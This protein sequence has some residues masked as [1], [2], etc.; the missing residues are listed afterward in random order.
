[1]LALGLATFGTGLGPGGT[2]LELARADRVAG[3]DGRRRGRDQLTTLSILTNI[4]PQEERPKAIAVW[5]AVAG[6]GIAIGPISAA[7]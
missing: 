4:F 5:A 6:L 1:M 2:V 7:G 3:A